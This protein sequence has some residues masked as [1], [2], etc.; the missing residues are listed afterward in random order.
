MLGYGVGN[1]CDGDKNVPSLSAKLKSKYL[2]ILDLQVSIKVLH[3]V[4]RN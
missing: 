3:N 2:Y 1:K 4:Y